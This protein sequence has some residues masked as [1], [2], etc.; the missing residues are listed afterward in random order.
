MA[1]VLQAGSGTLLPLI[2]IACLAFLSAPR[3]RGGEGGPN[4]PLSVAALILL[5]YAIVSEDVG[6]RPLSEG[7]R[8]TL[9]LAAGI[10]CASFR[11]RKDDLEDAVAFKSPLSKWIQFVMPLAFFVGAESLVDEWSRGSVR[12]MAPMG[13]FM[14]ALFVT[15]LVLSQWARTSSSKR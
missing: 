12:R 14:G 9:S 10:A 1:W 5:A 15:R 11:I 2:A 4:L 6:Q 8:T 7:V 13:E 3:W